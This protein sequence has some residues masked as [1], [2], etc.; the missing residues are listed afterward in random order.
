VLI[1][2]LRGWAIYRVFNERATAALHPTLDDR[3]DC[4][5]GSAVVR[6]R[7]RTQERS[8]VGTVE[9]TVRESPGQQGFSDKPRRRGWK[10]KMGKEKK[11]VEGQVK[12]SRVGR[13]FQRKP[14]GKN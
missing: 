13:F 11:P 6:A 8:K 5:L 7:D 2:V 14:G 10:E 3:A 4:V 1:G 9:D 12:L